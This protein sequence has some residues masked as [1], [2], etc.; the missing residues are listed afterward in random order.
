MV[1]SVTGHS[2]LPV[3]DNIYVGGVVHVL[4]P[5]LF[6]EVQTAKGRLKN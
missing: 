5:P 2:G 1:T 6:V 4:T 3:I